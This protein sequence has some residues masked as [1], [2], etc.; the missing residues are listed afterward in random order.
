MS[1]PT[2]VDLCAGTGGLSLG[3]K[4][5]GFKGLLSVEKEADNLTNY[6]RNFPGIP[7]RCTSITQLNGDDLPEC[8]VIAGGPPCQGFSVM[9]KQNPND[10]RSLMVDEFW[11]LVFERRPKWAVMENVPQLFDR[12]EIVLPL[13][14]R[15]RANGY[16]VDVPWLLNA[17]HLTPQHRK[18]LFLVAAREDVKLPRKPQLEG[19][20]FTVKDAIYDLRDLARFSFLYE[21]DR[22][23]AESLPSPLSD[24]AVKV[25]K[26]FGAGMLSG[27]RLTR[28]DRQTIQR[29][30]TLYGG[31]RDPGGHGTRLHWDGYAPTLT[32]STRAKQNISAGTAKRPIH[33]QDHRVLTVREGARLQGFPD[34]FLLPAGICDGWRQIGQ[35][36]PPPLGKAIAEAISLVI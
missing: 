1:Q 5:A 35:A 6:V 11:R 28:H 9:G 31:D 23:E 3:F 10:P 34:S 25:C 27:V 32:S 18:R 19:R 33:P 22:I 24:Y 16:R 2:F 13:L 12:T 21:Q 30:R 20:P 8:D 15:I 36:V 4:Q 29:F 26:A 17:I 14:D 7:Y